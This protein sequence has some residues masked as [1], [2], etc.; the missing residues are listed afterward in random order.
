MAKSKKEKPFEIKL[1]L[2]ENKFEE[3][4]G[5][6]LKTTDEGSKIVS[7]YYKKVYEK[8]IENLSKYFWLII[9]SQPK[10]I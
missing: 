10:E 5:F 4:K 7:C 1:D 9:E 3:G 2:L 8:A 6:S